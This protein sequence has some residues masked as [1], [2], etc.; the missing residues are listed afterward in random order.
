MRCLERN[1]RQMWLSTY[2][3]Q[4]LVDEETGLGTGECVASWSAPVSVRVNVAP[5]TGSAESSPFGTEVSYDLVLVADS[6]PWGIAEGCRMWLGP[7][8]PDPEDAA[9][10]YEVKRVSP[11][12]NF[13]AFGLTR[14]QGA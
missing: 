9:D 2:A 4:E 13:V 14:R 10:A 1:K 5:Q 8:K 6:N 12:L 7:T 3:E 11:S